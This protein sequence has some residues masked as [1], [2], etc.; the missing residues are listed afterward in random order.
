MV[1]VNG[2]ERREVARL[3]GGEEVLPPATLQVHQALQALLGMG[4]HNLQTVR[5]VRLVENP[6]E[7]R[8]EMQILYNAL[9]AWKSNRNSCMQ[10]MNTTVWRL[11]FDR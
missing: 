6:S 1:V 3:H 2:P 9:T 8:E 7:E 4:L 11:E 5:H 10:I